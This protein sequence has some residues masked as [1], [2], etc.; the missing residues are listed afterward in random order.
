MIARISKSLAIA[1]L[2]TATVAFA[3]A[4]DYSQLDPKTY[5]PAV[6]PNIDMFISS[7]K[8]SMPHHIFGSLIERKIFIPLKGN[9]PVKPTSRGAV[10]TDCS[11][12]SHATLALGTSTAPS[13]LEGEQIVF[14]VY[15]GKGTIKA[16]KKSADLYDGIGILMPPG[17]EFIMKNTGEEPLTM[18]LIGEPVPEG[19][20]TNNEMLVRDENVIEPASSTVH[21]CHIYKLLFGK[22]HG[23]KTLIGMGPVWFDPWTMGQPHS[24]GE[25]VEEIWFSLTDNVTILLGKQIRPFPTGT[26]YKIPPNGK[27]PHSTINNTDKQIKVFWFMKVPKN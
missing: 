14:Y 18:F 21:W 5:D 3:Q 9:N 27:T 22:E 2:F 8:E 25:G 23:L 4:P 26:A 12:M 20:K 15:G 24:H 11:R 13:K 17:L 6:D 10:L 7:W 1:L 16:G 19:T